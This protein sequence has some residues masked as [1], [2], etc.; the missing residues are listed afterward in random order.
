MSSDSGYFTVN[1][2]ALLA[3][4]TAFVSV[5]RLVFALPILPNVQPMT[6]LLILVTL[7]IGALDGIV[8]SVLSLLLTNLIL[9]TGPWTIMQMISFGVLIIV[10]ALLKFFYSYGT[11]VNR[12]VFS[13]WAGLAG[14]IFG[15]LMTYMS[16]RLYGISN[17]WIYY[18]NGLPFDILHAAGNIIFFVILEPVIVPI[19]QRKFKKEMR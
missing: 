18:I 9:G 19:I 11:V 6:A 13:I 5:G 7:N 3:V 15:F 8:V 16:F 17:F 10:T 14:F 12:F 2:I 1:R 4:L